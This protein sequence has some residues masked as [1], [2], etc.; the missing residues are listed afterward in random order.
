[1]VAI[2]CGGFSTRMGT[3]KGL[4]AIDDTI[5]AKH[6]ANQFKYL[7][8]PVLY[9]LRKSQI[10]AYSKYI[11]LSNVVIDSTSAEGPLNGLLSVHDAFPHKN[12]LLVACDMIDIDFL[13]IDALVTSYKKENNMS[14]AFKEGNFYEPCCAIYSTNALLMA[15]NNRE[16]KSLQWLLKT[17]QV[18]TLSKLGI[19]KNYNTLQ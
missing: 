13:T 6:I 5:W 11:Q 12:I 10:E 18:N 4:I 16:I 3:D 1:M 19:W 15:K 9:S 7:Y 17:V 14:H 2:L 8:V